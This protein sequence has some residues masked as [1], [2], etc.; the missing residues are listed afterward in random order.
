MEV[1][2]LSA[3]Y[4]NAYY[5]HIITKTITQYLWKVTIH[6]ISILLHNLLPITYGK[7]Q[8]YQHIITKTITHYL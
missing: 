7:L 2:V 5:K 6:I 4:H 1:T 3:S 8:H